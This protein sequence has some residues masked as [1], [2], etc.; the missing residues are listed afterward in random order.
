MR[1]RTMKTAMRMRAMM[2]MAAAIIIERLL[3]ISCDR[4]GVRIT[5]F[6]GA[7]EGIVS[8]L[9]TVGE[10]IVGADSE[11]AMNVPSQIPLTKT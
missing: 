7:R 6:G 3:E 2:R 8:C 11:P 9:A 4:E 10:G 5:R 1:G